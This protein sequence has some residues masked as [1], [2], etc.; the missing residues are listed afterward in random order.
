MPER[1][2][3]ELEQFIK[4][5][6]WTWAKTYAETWPHHYIVRDR[7]DKELFLKFV[8]HIREYGEW[9]YFYNTQ[10]KYFEQDGMVYWTMVPKEQGPKWYMPEEEDIINMC[11]VE[12]TYKNRLKED[13]LPE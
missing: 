7:V 6:K 8:L 5:V 9:E 1:L 2:P 13:T 3:Q 11:P 12:S 10:L 4:E